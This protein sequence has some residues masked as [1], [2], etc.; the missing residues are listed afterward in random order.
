MFLSSNILKISGIFFGTI[1]I[2]GSKNN[3][4]SSGNIRKASIMI[5]G[6]NNTVS[7]EEG[8]IFNLSVRIEGDNH[9]LYINKSRTIVNSKIIMLD[10]STKVTIGNNTGLAGARIVVGGY[11]NYIYI[12]DDCMFSDNVEIWATDSHSIINASTHER[13]NLDKPIVI[14]NHVWIGSGVKILKGVTIENNVVI[15]M[16]S[17]VVN[18]ISA[19]TLS[20][21]TPN[22]MIKKDID[23]LIERLDV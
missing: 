11:D 7:V 3:I 1:K 17:T 4:K 16:G 20:A 19:N 2:I 6:D 9:A 10:G 14:K 21:G 15:G 8:S 18:D 5:I 12:G 22:K 23:W 13:I